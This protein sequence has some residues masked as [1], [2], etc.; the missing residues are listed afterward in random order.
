MFTFLGVFCF[1]PIVIYDLLIGEMILRSERRRLYPSTR[2]SQ[3]S[4]DRNGKVNM[5][6]IKRRRYAPPTY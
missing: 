6:T 3:W 1:I 5:F 2:H 4:G